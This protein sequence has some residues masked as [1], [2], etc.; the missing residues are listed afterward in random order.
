MDTII[1]IVL[2]I[3]SFMVG[4]VQFVI[5]VWLLV[6]IYNLIFNRKKCKDAGDAFLHAYSEYKT[7]KERA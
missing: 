5:G 3:C 4:L 6:C 1:W 7:S 2:G